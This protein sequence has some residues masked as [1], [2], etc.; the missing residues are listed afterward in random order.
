MGVQLEKYVYFRKKS[1]FLEGS[2]FICLVYLNNM[3]ISLDTDALI[4]IHPASNCRFT[5]R[6]IGCNQ[7]KMLC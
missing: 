5:V 2:Y 3:S 7:N 6:Y 4:D 1:E